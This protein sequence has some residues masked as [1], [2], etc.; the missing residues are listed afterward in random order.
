MN[1][2][3]KA[4]HSRAARLR[5]S[6]HCNAP[7]VASVAARARIGFLEMQVQLYTG[8][9]PHEREREPRPPRVVLDGAN[10]WECNV[11]AIPFSCTSIQREDEHYAMVGERNGQP[12]RYT[13][14]LTSLTFLFHFCKFYPH[15]CFNIQTTECATVGKFLS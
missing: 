3:H 8:G 7:W 9:S 14:D 10:E 6:S 4:S 11:F 1:T 15:F 2:G 5:S 13:V 12:L